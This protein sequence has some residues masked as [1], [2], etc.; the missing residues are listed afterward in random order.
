MTDKISSY[1]F[2]NS[3]GNMT[4]AVVTH[5]EHVS[6]CQCNGSGVIRIEGPFYASDVPCYCIAGGI[7]A[8]L[9]GAEHVD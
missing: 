2:V 1:E 7:T 5:D 3:N 9:N 8:H 6:P 4:V